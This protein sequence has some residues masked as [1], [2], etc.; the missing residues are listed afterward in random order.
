[1]GRLP[2]GLLMLLL[3]LAADAQ[4]YRCV[5]ERGAIQYTDKPRA[6]CKATDIRASP[7]ISGKLE[8][9]REDFATRD[10]EF[11]RRQIEQSTTSASERQALEQRCARLRYEQGLL[12]S[13][14]RLAQVTASGERV[15]LDDATRER[16]LVSLREQ[17]RAC[18]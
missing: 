6:G 1:M 13:G 8:E 11:R 2:L 5:D 15:Y 16:R 18:P 17:L 10:A 7:P 3:P 4:M 14:G 9:R 12:S